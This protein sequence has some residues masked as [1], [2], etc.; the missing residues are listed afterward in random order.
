MDDIK[1][2]KQQW[3]REAKKFGLSKPDRKEYMQLREGG[4]SSEQA[5]A[6]I[7]NDILRQI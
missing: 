3:F 6:R 2:K 1:L 7:L 5:Y 4:L